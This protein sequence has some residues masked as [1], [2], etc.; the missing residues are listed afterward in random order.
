MRTIS[1]YLLSLMLVLFMMVTCDE[2]TPAPVPTAPPEE[3][4]NPVST[5]SIEMVNGNLTVIGC[6][7]AVTS[8]IIP[9]DVTS[10]GNGA[11]QNCINLTSITIPDGVPMIGVYAF[12]GCT[13]LTSNSLPESLGNEYEAQKS[14]TSLSWGI[15]SPKTT[16]SHSATE[17]LLWNAHPL[18][19][20]YA[21]LKSVLSAG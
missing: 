6:D 14:D 8:Y 17:P 4:D 15:Q 2:A 12:Y 7:I 11:F 3:P 16:P 21:E 1:S 13:N 19:S 5:L 9:D 18:L 20:L 10:I